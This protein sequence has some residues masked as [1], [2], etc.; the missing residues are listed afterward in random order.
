MKRMKRKLRRVAALLLVTVM[1]L[2]MVQTASATEDETDEDSGTAVVAESEESADPD[3]E[4]ADAV[5]TDTEDADAV[6]PDTE[7]SADPDTE[8]AD[9][10]DAE[11]TDAVNTDTDTSDTDS[12]DTNTADAEAEDEDS[13]DAEAEETEEEDTVYV[14]MNIPYAEFYAAELT[15][16]VEVDTVSSA[17]SSKWSRQDGTYYEATDEGGT[18][19]GVSFPVI[20]TEEALEE[21]GAV[22][23]ESEDDLATAGSYAYLVVDVDTYNYSKELT[24]T[25]GEASFA[26]AEYE[27]EAV[28]L[29]DATYEFSTSSNYGDYQLNIS[30][31]TLSGTVYG[32]ILETEEGTS[33]GLRALE[34]IWRSGSQLSWAVNEETYERHGNL[35]SYEHYASIVG[36]TITQVTYLTSDGIYYV[37]LE[38]YVAYVSDASAEAE[39]VTLGAETVTVTLTDL[40]ED[41]EPVFTIDDEEVEAV[42]NGD[43]TYTLT[44]TAT[45]I[46]SVTVTITDGSG[47]YTELSAS[48][49]VSTETAYAEYDE[50]AVALVAAEGISEEEFAAYL[51]AISSV[52]VDGTSYSATGRDSATIINED[53][54]VNLDATVSS[55]MGPDAETVAIFESGNTY[56]IV[57]SATGYPD[58]EFT[59]TIA[60]EEETEEST[61]EST[62]EAETEEST[63]EAE[64]GESTTEAETTASGTITFEDS[65]STVTSGDALTFTVTGTYSDLTV[66]INGTVVDSSYL[67]IAA[68]TDGNTVVTVSADY[69]STLSEGSYTLAVSEDGTMVLDSA[70][71]TVAAETTTTAAS[72][73]TTTTSST[74]TTA[75]STTSDS[76]ETGDSSSMMLYAALMMIALG[77]CGAMAAVTWKKK[78]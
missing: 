56:T 49:T 43:G 64:T 12:E 62:T 41:Y 74:T 57:V 67:T 26:A 65:S 11:D 14:L 20:T 68:D 63:T 27:E 39:D 19:L 59:L 40:E 35:L 50:D 4:E 44:Y 28:E 13:A 1:V 21:L 76:T 6:N 55:G 46:G 5:N 73:E 2:G 29:T 61:E 70:T 10:A 23:V 30:S 7:E 66:M 71:I 17:T 15:N 72:E 60:A 38:Q 36:Q 45:E 75:S 77:A 42:D 25:D 37:T 18:I 53:G 48:F 32:V 33:Y 24:V 54:S 47:K 8:D 58:I 51:S 52:S 16:D 22:E 78:Y 69:M 3:T 31:S 34:N 9:A